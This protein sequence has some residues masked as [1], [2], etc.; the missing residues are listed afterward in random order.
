MLNNIT[1]I[2]VNTGLNN[3]HNERWNNINRKI[4]NLMNI[5]QLHSDI[6]LDDLITQSNFNIKWM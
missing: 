4:S 6:I 3:K 2:L 5:N 1:L